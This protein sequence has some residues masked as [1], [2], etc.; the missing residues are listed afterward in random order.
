MHNTPPQ[1]RARLSRAGFR[2]IPPSAG[3]TFADLAGG[4]VER[5]LRES[6]AIRTDP[7]F[8]VVRASFRR[9]A[10]EQIALFGGYGRW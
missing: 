10:S 3:A 2:N 4:T 9:S 8:P 6:G 5:N 7:R 1:T